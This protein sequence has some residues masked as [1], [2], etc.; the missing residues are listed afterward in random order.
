MHLDPKIFE[1]ELSSSGGIC[2]TETKKMST[3]DSVHGC[4]KMISF[5][6]QS[7]GNVS[8]GGGGGG[9]RH[10]QRHDK[11]AQPGFLRKIL[12]KKLIVIKTLGTGRFDPCP[13]L[14]PGSRVLT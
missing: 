13:K 10:A 9:T 8:G 7:C 5:K 2:P 11:D 3:L 6:C 14:K 12:C 4:R 1:T